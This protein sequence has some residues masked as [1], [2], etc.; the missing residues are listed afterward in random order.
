MTTNKFKE[1]VNP[2]E[3]ANKSGV[4]NLL[5]KSLI[6]SLFDS[7]NGEYDIL[8]E[9]VQ[10]SVDAIEKLYT[11]SNSSI[12]GNPEIEIFIDCKNDIIR[13]SDNG[14]GVNIDE[15]KKILAPNYTDKTFLFSKNRKKYRGHKGVGLTYIGYS[16]NALKFCSKI[17]G[18]FISCEFRD[19][20]TWVQ[21]EEN[22]TM[23]PQI[24]PSVFLPD[25]VDKHKRGSS[26]ETQLDSH[27]LP[28][29]LTIE[30]W[31]FILRTQS[32]IGYFN[33]TSEE[34]WAKNVTV[35]LVYVDRQGNQ[36][37]KDVK[38]EFVFPH[39]I[40]KNSLQLR[41][42]YRKYPEQA[43]PIVSERNKYSCIYEF[44]DEN[45]LIEKFFKESESDYYTFCKE[46]KPTVYAAFVHSANLWREMDKE[47]TTDARRKLWKAGAQIVTKN[48][49]TGRQFP[50][51]VS[52]TASRAD[53]IFLVISLENVRPD[54]GRKIF[55]EDVY[56][57]VNI[58]GEDI[59]N[60]FVDNNVLLKPTEVA[61]HGGNET[62][63]E[64]NAKRRIEEARELQD[65]GLKKLC[66]E[67]E[68]VYEQDV[69]ALFHE[70][71]GNGELKGYKVLSVSSSGQYD[72]VIRYDL[73]NNTDVI[74]DKRRR[75]L[76]L[77]ES[78]FGKKG[79]IKLFPNN[80]E[81]KVSLSDL[82]KNFEGGTKTFDDIKFA[83]VWEV[84]ESRAFKKT[85]YQLVSLLE[86][87]NESKRSFYG[88]THLLYSEASLQRPINVIC[89]K[90]VI[91]LLK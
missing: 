58:L 82:I 16:T 19:A 9:L 70:L 83:V 2:I 32:A 26:F 5:A 69:V 73:P 87:D 51:S 91:E 38:F 39:E 72:A 90:S 10:N 67:K 76:G 54:F 44:W 84:G 37:K 11:D 64:Y 57:F 13:V 60:Y 47:L 46:H 20:K 80:L 36:A 12:K 28:K 49:P 24:R 41:E 43:S 14:V 56:E 61:A 3:E 88:V 52:F 25:F 50:I 27:S 23:P 34:E 62:E 48:M 29:T 71:L 15:A 35:K 79:E 78:A 33:I 45:Q 21:D 17:N 59:I 75:P 7:Y 18:D 6:G 74:Y 86:N 53:R 85:A 63:R 40:R 4:V 30:G 77:H 68:P 66:F 55:H 8:I 65:L 1:I 42:Y 81:F 89:L 22:K 31:E